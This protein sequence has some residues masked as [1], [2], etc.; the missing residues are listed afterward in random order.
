MLKPAGVSGTTEY[1]F[2]IKSQFWPIL[3]LIFPQRSSDGPWTSCVAIGS[4]NAAFYNGTRD[5]LTGMEKSIRS[6]ITDS[7][8]VS[9][10]AAFTIVTI[11]SD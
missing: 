7:G 8:R 6:E 10:E 1:C 5:A 11:V 2:W 4:S 9:L 3:K